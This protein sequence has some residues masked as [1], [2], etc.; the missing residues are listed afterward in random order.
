MELGT[1]HLVGVNDPAPFDPYK[2]IKFRDKFI[3]ELTREELLAALASS[4]QAI[5]A[6]NQLRY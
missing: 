5:H 4:L 3:T 2:H 6:L 1:R